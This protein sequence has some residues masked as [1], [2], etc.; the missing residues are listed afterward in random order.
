MPVQPSKKIRRQSVIA[1]SRLGIRGP[2]SLYQAVVRH[3]PACVWLGT[4][5][6]GAVSA[7]ASFVDS[8]TTN[9]K[10][11]FLSITCVYFYCSRTLLFLSVMA[12]VE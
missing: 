5:I 12:G 2:L 10:M 9:T 6:S 3:S 8:T 1:Y 7:A 4:A 11:I